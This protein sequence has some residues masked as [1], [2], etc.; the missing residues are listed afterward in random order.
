MA[1]TWAR[2]EAGGTGCIH[3]H[4]SVR[5]RF[6]GGDL[7]VSCVCLCV[8][9]KGELCDECGIRRYPC[10]HR[11]RLSDCLS[12]VCDTPNAHSIAHFSYGLT[13][14]DDVDVDDD[15]DVA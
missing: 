10:D 7:R 2:A 6:G 5:F 9:V 14:H 8:C 11:Y 3:H 15:D 1:G 4:Y 13:T 12:A